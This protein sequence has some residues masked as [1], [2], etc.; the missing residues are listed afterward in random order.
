M[1]GEAQREGLASPERLICVECGRRADANA[2]G[3]RAFLT[4]DDEAA[5]FCPD[6]AEREFGE[7]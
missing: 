5:N 1:R 7:S 2:E 6:C 3:W 4:S